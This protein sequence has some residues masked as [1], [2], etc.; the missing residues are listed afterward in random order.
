MAEELKPEVWLLV[1]SRYC[2]VGYSVASGFIE[3]M[4]E[5][6]VLRKD[7]FMHYYDDIRDLQLQQQQAGHWV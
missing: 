6:L 1:L 4:K 5:V 7:K 2:I 3:A